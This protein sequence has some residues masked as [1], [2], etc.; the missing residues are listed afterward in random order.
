MNKLYEFILLTI[1]LLLAGNVLSQKSN[2]KPIEIENNYRERFS[3]SY[4]PDFIPK[5]SKL[6]EI[7]GRVTSKQ[8]TSLNFDLNGVL[9]EVKENDSNLIEKSITDSGGYFILKKLEYDKF[10]TVYF[11][12][13]GFYTR[14][15]R[16]YTYFVP[17]SLKEK[18]FASSYGSWLVNVI[19]PLNKIIDT[20]I[21]YPYEKDIAILMYKPIELFE[22]RLVEE[23]SLLA[24]RLSNFLE[25]KTKY[26]IIK[27]GGI[28]EDLNYKKS[29]EEWENNQQTIRTRETQKK[30]DKLIEDYQL[31]VK[32]QELEKEKVEKEKLLLSQSNRIKESE[33]AE[34]KAVASIQKQEI[35]LANQKQKIQS[36]EQQKKE[37][38]HQAELK[39]KSY[40]LASVFT[41]LLIAIIFSG[42]IFRSLL[43]TKKQKVLIEFKEKETQKQKQLVEE[44]NREILDSI[45]YAL[46]I[47]TAILPPQKIVKQY[48]D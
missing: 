29:N 37:V 17:D 41:F 1:C 24:K 19:I 31:K 40:T 6:S 42:F 10:Y 48:L 43:T 45:E 36:I 27:S 13:E 3:F 35:N 33:I 15:L 25:D 21:K 8:L 9:I 32:I 5:F 28:V 39:Q 38:V 46:R 2:T 34:Q 4:G 23:D 26:L 11:S 47:Q 7:A 20:T 44:K 18:R 14:S 30:S 22:Y 16:I 12:K